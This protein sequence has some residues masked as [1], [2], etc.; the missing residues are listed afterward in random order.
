MQFLTS[1][2]KTPRNAV[3][4]IFADILVELQEELLCVFIVQRT[5]Q[6]ALG[7]CSRTAQPTIEYPAFPFQS[8]LT[9]YVIAVPDR[10]IARSHTPRPINC[11]RNANVHSIIFQPH[12]LFTHPKMKSDSDV[13][14]HTISPAERE[15][16]SQCSTSSR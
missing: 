3:P 15:K 6:T 13:R 16:L 4:T 2:S 9:G 14:S 1:K 7:G 10:S 5:P 8:S 12:S 11:R